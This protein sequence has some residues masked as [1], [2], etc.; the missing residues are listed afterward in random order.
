MKRKKLTQTLFPI[1]SF[2]LLLNLNSFG[3]EINLTGKVTD[4]AGERL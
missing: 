2:I 1:L 3:Q 4:A